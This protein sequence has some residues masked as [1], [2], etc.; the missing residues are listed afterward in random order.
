MGFKVHSIAVGCQQ[1]V[2]DTYV[3]FSDSMPCWSLLWFMS[4]ATGTTIS[5]SPPL[6]AYMLIS[7]TMEDRPNKEGSEIRLSSHTLSP[8]S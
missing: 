8:V 3:T 2:S 5:C 1:H 6:A 4:I 7:G